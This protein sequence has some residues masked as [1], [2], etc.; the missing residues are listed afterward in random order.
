MSVDLAFMSATD[1]VSRYR[2]GSVS[3]VE[4]VKACL[5]Q[6]DAHDARLNAFRMVVPEQ[7]LEAARR[8]EARWARGEPCGL[9]DGVP[10]SIKDSHDVR[11]WSTLHG[12]M[13]TD[14][15]QE[16]AEDSPHVARLREHGAVFLGKTNLC[17][18]GWK[19]VTD[20]PRTG[21][22]RNPWN[23]AKT[24]AGS[25]GGAA[26]AAAMGMAAINMGGDGGGSIRMPAAFCGV[27]GIKPTYGRV[28]RYPQES[29]IKCAHFG[30]LTRS[31]A[32]AAL[33]MTVITRPD[34]RD[35]TA[36]PFDDR[37]YLADLDGGLNG[38]RIAFST[39]FGGVRPAP[40][41]ADSVTMAVGQLEAHGAI[42]EE[43]DPNLG[44]TFE[45]YK[46]LNSA[47]QAPKIHG[48]SPDAIA[49]MDALLVANARVGEALTVTEV[50][51]A[52]YE[53]RRWAEKMAAFH[54]RYDVLITPTSPVAPFDV[55]RNNP[56]ALVDSAAK[57]D[58]VY[59]LFN[60]YLYQ[61]NY[62]HQPA[63]SVPCGLTA[64]G[65]PVGLQIIGPKLSDA[66]LLK[67]AR[68]VEQIRPIDHAKLVDGPQPKSGRTDAF[69]LSSSPAIRA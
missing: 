27:F 17:E 15:S 40:E 54:R 69:Y 52:G 18:F 41:I 43:A 19:C 59:C 49:E 31:V 39:R 13:T 58:H 36:L 28:P 9:L 66:L 20:S 57:G 48:R 60:G 8:S 47:Y 64:D 3:P 4:V 12:S 33:A 26:V 68:A 37:D 56:S 21:I 62:T 46:V 14:P 30:P 1:L 51:D 16:A 11:G 42:V 2:A 10:T 24:P 67:I 38:L 35:I 50:L 5:A 65:L 34:A 22:T 63:V 7:A 29:L 53:I 55:G 45:A 32:D 25:S 44:D 23:P 6:I 61:T